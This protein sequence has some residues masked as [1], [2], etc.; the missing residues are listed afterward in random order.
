MKNIN[1]SVR[2]KNGRSPIKILVL[3]RNNDTGKVVIDTELK[4]P[5]DE[6]FELSSANYTVFVSG[7]NPDGGT[8]EITVS[9]DFTGGGPFPSSKKITTSKHITG[10]FKG[11]I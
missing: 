6:K 2:V 11:T 10:F 1:F 3:I 8:T 7:L 4:T 5:I 9:G